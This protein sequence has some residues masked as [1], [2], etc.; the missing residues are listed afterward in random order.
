MVVARRKCLG[1]LAGA[2]ALLLSGCSSCSRKTNPATDAGAAPTFSLADAALPPTLAPGL[3]AEI[4]VRVES[5]YLATNEEHTF[6]VKG[7]RVRFPIPSDKL[8]GA[9][10]IGIF[11]LPSKKIY[12]RRD[13]EKTFTIVD[14]VLP[15]DPRYDAG[16]WQITKT[17]QKLIVADRECD[18]WLLDRGVRKVTAC[19]A[20][21]IAYMDFALMSGKKAPHS[22]CA[23]ELMSRGVFPMRLEEHDETGGVAIKSF[24]LHITKKAFPEAHFVV[25]GSFRH[26][27][28]FVPT[29][30]PQ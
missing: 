9:P 29:V 5:P 15:V 24:V 28:T 13:D 4:V 27:K 2:A 18:V 8:G 22:A 30:L 26:V 12:K 14:T 11:E 3:E 21:G 23:D 25:P 1:A 10:S 7:D 19:V 6:D 16:S 20:P 17:G